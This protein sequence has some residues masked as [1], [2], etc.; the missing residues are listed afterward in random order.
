MGRESRLCSEPKGG[1]SSEMGERVE[2]WTST[3]CPA[4]IIPR[5]MQ[6]DVDAQTRTYLYSP[7]CR[8]YE[9]VPRRDA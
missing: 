1:L 8:Y 9:Y 6:A 4:C 2:D 7:T 3:L 5:K